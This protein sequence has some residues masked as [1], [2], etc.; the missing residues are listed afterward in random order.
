[1][2][3]LIFV[4][5][6]FWRWDGLLTSNYSIILYLCGIYCI[7]KMRN[8]RLFMSGDN[9]L[10]LYSTGYIHAIWNLEKP[11][12]GKNDVTIAKDKFSRAAKRTKTTSLSISKRKFISATWDLTCV[13]NSFQIKIGP[14]RKPCHD[15]IA[16]FVAGKLCHSIIQSWK[17]RYLRNL[18]KFHMKGDSAHSSFGK[19]P[20]AISVK[21]SRW[22]IS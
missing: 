13:D 17:D 12:C 10:K 15:I 22:H 14:W 19:L 1:M 8:G 3:L 6:A 18:C 21:M 20:V 4:Y 16:V 9:F 2:S 5:S 11:Q 7:V